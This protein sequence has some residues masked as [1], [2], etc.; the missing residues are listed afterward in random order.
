MSS[1]ARTQNTS[2]FFLALAV[3]VA[4]HAN[5]QTALAPPAPVPPQIMAAKK[6]FISNA[7]IDAQSLA[8]FK[9]AGEPDQPYNEFYAAA[10]SWGRYDLVSSP[11]DADLIFQIRYTAPLFGCQPGDSYAPQLAVT[12]LDAKSHFVLWSLSAPVKGAFKK[13]TWNKNFA[14]GIASIMDDLK[15]LA[16]SPVASEPLKSKVFETL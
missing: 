3:L 16:N 7:G 14:E 10:K 15:K 13:D 12:I 6:A 4:V 5:A 11:A 9:K 2:V 1:I 8:T